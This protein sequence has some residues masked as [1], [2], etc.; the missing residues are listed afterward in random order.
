[1]SIPFHA[2]CEHAYDPNED[3][4][5]TKCYASQCC[6]CKDKHNCGGEMKA[7]QI[8]NLKEGQ[9]ILNKLLTTFE[10]QKKY[11]ETISYEGM[12]P[13]M[14][15]TIKKIANRFEECKNVYEFI[16][17]INSLGSVMKITRK[18][19][20]NFLRVQEFFKSRTED[21]GMIKDL[22]DCGKD[23][24]EQN[25]S[26]KEEEKKDR[27]NKEKLIHYGRISS[28]EKI[29]ENKKKLIESNK[30]DIHQLEETKDRLNNE[31]AKKGEEIQT[32]EKIKE[33]INSTVEGGKSLFKKL[34]KLFSDCTEMVLDLKKKIKEISVKFVEESKNKAKRNYIERVIF[35]FHTRDVVHFG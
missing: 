26:D 34:N 11:V 31:I 9:N 30:K 32:Q 19:Y 14:G 24:L 21:Y 8:I 16:D 35:I 27:W 23:L 22:I 12:N 5:C 6:K 13:K 17:T 20:P 2:D 25:A 3:F 4:I 29:I 10:E 7:L 1:M 15:N 33:T 18:N 28:L